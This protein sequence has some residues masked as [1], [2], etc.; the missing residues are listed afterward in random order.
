[1]G[2]LKIKTKSLAAFAMIVAATWL[3][4]TIAE[5]TPPQCRYDANGAI[6]YRACAAATEPGSA[7]FALSMINLGTQAFDEGNVTEAVRLY[8]LAILPGSELTSDPTLHARRASALS[9]V[10]R[11]NEALTDARKAYA[12][13]AHP[14]RFANEIP[15]ELL[16]LN[17]RNRELVYVLVLPIL[18]KANDPEA[19]GAIAAWRALPAEGW[20][21]LVNRAAV[22]EQLGALED[23]LAF[24]TRAMEIEPSHPAVLNNQCY[25]LVRS[26]RAAEALPFC[27][28]AVRAAPDAGAVHHSHASAL[29]ALGRCAE[30]DA[31]IATAR[32]LEP[33]SASNQKPLACTA[34]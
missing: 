24:N 3:S 34:S 21:I 18:A 30:A 13:I 15:A 14:E 2:K 9:A 26:N 23:A 11:S 6:D 8:D 33:G 1:V 12:M 10:G 27:E 31:A 28:R 22:M 7:L 29:A 16:R 17:D 32:R 5:E 25:I 19:P 20:D 4:P